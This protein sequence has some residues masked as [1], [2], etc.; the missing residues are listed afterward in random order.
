M[1]GG[2]LRDKVGFAELEEARVAYDS[3]LDDPFPDHFAETIKRE[4]GRIPG[5]WRTKS[6]L[7]AC[8]HLNLQ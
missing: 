8:G 5:I 1:K 2:S 7:T 6:N 4:Q 3:I